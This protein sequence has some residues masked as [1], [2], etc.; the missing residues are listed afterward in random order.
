[1]EHTR[2]QLASLLPGG[3]PRR[4]VEVASSSVI[5][6]HAADRMPCPQCGGHY[7]ILEHTRPVPGLRRIDAECRYC[8]VPRVLWYRIVTDE[9]N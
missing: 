9:P 6:G 7:R 5:E 4:P 3:S 2:E 8:G 1:M